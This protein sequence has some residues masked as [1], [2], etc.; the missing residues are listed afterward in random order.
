M[1][2]DLVAAEALMRRDIA[3]AQEQTDV[4]AAGGQVDVNFLKA[5]RAFDEARLQ[6]ALAAMK[7]ENAG[8]GRNEV[9]AAAGFSLGSTWG[10]ML[11]SCVGARERAIFNGWVHQALASNIGDKPAEK[12]M[13]SVFQPMAEG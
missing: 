2:Y 13:M 11:R 8:Y 5:Q 9:L 4:L 1:T 6:F 3:L 7:A 12:T 10:S